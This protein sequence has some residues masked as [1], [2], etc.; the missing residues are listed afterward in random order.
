MAQIF[1]DYAIFL[2]KTITVVIAIVII[3]LCMAAVI[4]R[5][6]MRDK[7]KIKITKINE[8]YDELKKTL[9]K[10][11]LGKQEQK[12]LYKK[13]KEQNKLTKQQ[14]KAGKKPQRKRIFVL[15]FDG[16]LRAS[17]AKDL[18]EEVTAI[19]TVA[20]P[21]DEV[22]IKIEST[23]GVMHGYGLAA[24]QLKRI[25]DRDIPLI[26]AV[27]KV[28][29]SGGYMMACVA[30]RIFAAP[31]AILG[32]IGVV[33]QLPNFHRFLKKHDVE[34]EQVIAG[35]YKRTLTLFGENTNKGRKKMQEEI[36]D[37]HEL[38]KTFIALHR[39]VVDIRT[40]A[41]GEHWFGTRARENRLV[42]ELI[43]SDDY[44]L[45]ASEKADIYEIEYTAQKGLLEKFGIAARKAWMKLTAAST[46]L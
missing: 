6:K 39:P 12:E 27:D 10:K 45:L 43:T 11:I 41:T 36:D 29:A 2:A 7:E 23:G 3:L 37:A 19:L 14:E 9:S 21:T 34:F 5:G 16:D 20:K 33:A 40:V 17:G 13:F 25:R 26:A 46:H 28:A 35:E 38:F 15:N 8:K 18:A 1:I 4:G 30:N 31:F 42:D 32:S 24:S 44:L 22:L